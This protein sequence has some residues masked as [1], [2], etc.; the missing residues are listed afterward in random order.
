M[1]RTSPRGSRKATQLKRRPVRSGAEPHRPKGRLLIIG[2]HDDKSDGKV[3]LRELA[4]AAEGG[5]L[6]VAT[7]ASEQPEAMWAEYESTFRSLGVR[8]LYQLKIESRADA[9]SARAMTVLEDA[10]AVFF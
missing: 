6:V 8:H 2:G 7:L 1:P 4:R 3:I 10:T 9:E 5:K